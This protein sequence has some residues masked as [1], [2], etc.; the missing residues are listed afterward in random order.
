MFENDL[1]QWEKKH[2]RQQNS[3]FLYPQTISS[4][5]I[6][7]SSFF[8]NILVEF[9]DNDPQSRAQHDITILGFYYKY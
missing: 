9:E 6:C 5:M 1:I 4:R 3:F 2:N 7:T 8:I